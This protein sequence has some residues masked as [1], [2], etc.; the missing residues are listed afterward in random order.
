MI[1]EF[2]RSGKKSAGLVYRP[3]VFQKYI[4]IINTFDFFSQE[5][6]L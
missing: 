3:L 2:G 5:S 1:A 6:K 4:M